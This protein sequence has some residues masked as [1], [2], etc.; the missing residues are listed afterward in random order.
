MRGW[1]QCWSANVQRMSSLR[2][3]WLDGVVLADSTAAQGGKGVRGDA[4][5]RRG[6]QRCGAASIDAAWRNSAGLWPCTGQRGAAAGG[7]GCSGARRVEEEDDCLACGP[8]AS[9]A[10]GWREEKRRA[11]AA[12][13]AGPGGEEGKRRGEKERGGPA[14][15]VLAHAEVSPFFFLK[16][17]QSFKFKQKLFKDIWKLNKYD[18]AFLTWFCFLFFTNISFYSQG[19]FMHKNMR[20]SK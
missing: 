9:A 3:A 10:R 19:Y 16:T 7:A 4:Q 11:A 2:A 20:R 8:G 14:G 5:G 17:N 12:D 6:V 18:L 1:A 15:L 13:R